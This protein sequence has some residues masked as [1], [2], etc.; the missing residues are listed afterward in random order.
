MVVPPTVFHPRYFFTSKF[1]AEF[2][3]RQDFDGK[4][5]LDLGCGSGILSLVAASAGARVTSIDI[6][7]SAVTAT[8]TNA[9]LNSLAEQISAREG[10]LVDSLDLDEGSFDCII[11]N[12]PYYPGDPLTMSERA[13]KGGLKNEFMSRLAPALP[14]LLHAQG[15]LLVVLSSDVDAQQLLGPFEG[16]GF[17]VRTLEIKKLTFETLA[18]VQI[19]RE[20]ANGAAMS[21]GLC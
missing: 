4:R 8:R 15:S 1:M 2:L 12:P 17:S 16:S 7:P 19:R 20:E 5:V 11:S 10:D 21:P 9:Q 18:I 13:F 6:N 14:R 3:K